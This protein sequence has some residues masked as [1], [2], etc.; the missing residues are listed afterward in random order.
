[1]TERV[2]LD[3]G[4]TAIKAGRIAEAGQIRKEHELPVPESG[5]RESFVDL[6]ADLAREVGVA[7]RLGVGWPGMTDVERGM[8]IESSNLTLLDGYPLREALAARLDLPAEAVTVWND[9]HCAALG[10][11]WLGAA[12]GVANALVITLGTGIGSG[13]ILSGEIHL[14]DAFG[15]ELG[16][17]SVRSDSEVV[18]GCG[19]TGC[20][21]TLA[22]ATAAKRRAREA[23][24][25]G[26]LPALAAR[27]RAAEGPERALFREV[28]RD[29]GRGLGGVLV[30]LDVRTFV[31]GGGFSRSLDLLEPG[32]R[33][34]MREC[35]TGARVDAV[36]VVPAQ[37]GPSAGWIGAARLALV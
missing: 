32:L 18:C 8:P 36:H 22:S 1:V 28:G 9:A 24:L 20:L 29:L 33:Q 37:L 21:E 4:G 35:S 6:L 5:D 16:H 25:E 30:M 2:G 10:E 11:L 34:G 15:A 19:N 31:I 14:G 26:D 27:A 3:V 7:E 17:L 13:L 23:G 12:R